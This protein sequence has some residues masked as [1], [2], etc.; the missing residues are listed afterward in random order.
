MPL[1][2][3]AKGAL[4]E[5]AGWSD[6][7]N[8]QARE[9]TWKEQEALKV[10]VK[11]C[12]DGEDG[13]SVLQW[14]GFRLKGGLRPFDATKMLA[15]VDGNHRIA[16]LIRKAMD[17]TNTTITWHF[18]VNTAIYKANAPSPWYGLCLP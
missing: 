11:A 17:P 4:V 3:V 8:V 13:E 12:Q 5:E 18:L 10:E 15:L 1:D 2:V 6:A 7:Y 16:G 9:L 14:S